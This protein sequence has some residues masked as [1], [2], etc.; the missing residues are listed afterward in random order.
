[1]EITKNNF[2]AFQYTKITT[3]LSNYS[4]TPDKKRDLKKY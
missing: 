3:D 1:M 2:F 4:S